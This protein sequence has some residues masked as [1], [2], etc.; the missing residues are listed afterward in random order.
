MSNATPFAS[1]MKRIG[2]SAWSHGV[3]LSGVVAIAATFVAEHYGGPKYLYALL[4]GMAFHHLSQV[5]RYSA[6]IEFAAKK[7]VRFG[8]ALLGLRIMLSDLQDLGWLGVF[9][10]ISGLVLT[11]GFGMWMAKR[12]QLPRSLGLLS[13]GGTAICGISATLAL[14]AT[15][16]PS[17]EVEE[18]TLLTAIG[19]AAFSTVAMVLYP[20]LVVA[21]SLTQ[22]EAGLFLGGAIHDVAQVV[23][24]GYIISPDVADSATLAKMFRVAMLMPLVI[25]FSLAFSRARSDS[26]GLGNVA[27]K[28][29]LI[30]G[31]LVV[32]VALAVLNNVVELPK[33]AVGFLSDLSGWCLVISIAA[34]GVKTSLQKLSELGWRPI[35]LL[36]SEA[37]FIASWM[38]GMVFLMRQFS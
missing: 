9:A 22:A 5:D 23:G 19:I 14:S 11:I 20:V 10:L 7:L 13:G 38:L 15:M 24:A 33:Q 21:L 36:A 26:A 4:M 34:L 1:L 30:P 3:A 37:L 35:I 28:P 18:M 8:V 17:K 2:F 16:P 6:G 31:F 29:G 32:F 25:V 12:L 27:K